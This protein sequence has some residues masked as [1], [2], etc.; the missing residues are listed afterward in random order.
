MH[1]GGGGVPLADVKFSNLKFVR[2]PTGIA[3]AGFQVVDNCYRAVELEVRY[4][5]HIYFR[6]TI[7]SDVQTSRQ[8]WARK[9]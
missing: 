3:V 6:C 9:P 8:V 2:S 4:E 1:G 5:M 7:I